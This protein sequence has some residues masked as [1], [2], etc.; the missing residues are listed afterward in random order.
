M[1]NK[2]LGSV[3]LISMFVLTI[4]AF[5]HPNE[6]QAIAAILTLGT[7]LFQLV[8]TQKELE[9]SQQANMELLD[10]LRLNS[11]IAAITGKLHAYFEMRQLSRVAGGT[12]PETQTKESVNARAEIPILIERL[13][14]LGKGKIER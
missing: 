7:V 1:V 3:V 2:K 14:E 6:S 11:E 10:Q 4:S 13:S 5:W 8:Q 12:N 9:S